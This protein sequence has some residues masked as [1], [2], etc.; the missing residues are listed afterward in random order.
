VFN[1]EFGTAGSRLDTCGLCHGNFNNDSDGRNAYGAAFGRISTH[2]SNPVAALLALQDQDPDQDGAPSAEEIA[3]LFM[4]GWSCADAGEASNAPEDLDSYVDPSNPGCQQQPELDC[5]DGADDDGDGAV[6]CADPDCEGLAAGG[7]LTGQPGICS[8]GMLLCQAGAEQCVADLGPGPEGPTG[9]ATCTDSVDN[10]CDGLADA[11]DP[12]CQ[13]AREADCSNGLDDDGDGPADCADPD[14]AGALL[15]SCDTQ[16]PGLCAA[17]SLTCSGGE[18]L[19]LADSPAEIEAPDGE[20]CT[21]SIDNDCDGLTDVDDP[22]C[23]I[24]QQEADVYAVELRA[25][26]HVRLAVGRATSR[27]IV[28]K[29]DGDLRSQLA[30]VEL[31][32][33]PIE[34]VSVGLDPGSMARRVDPGGGDSL[35]RFQAEL[36]CQ[37]SGTWM[38]E[39]TAVIQAS[40]NREGSD[41]RL[42]ASTRVICR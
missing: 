8:A 17:G 30:T 24:S 10:D 32:V 28:V 16:E 38:L 5:F 18:A 23:Q 27:W 11:L 12:G 6:D 41:D 31:G 22:D 42:S 33:E 29:A 4:P 35:F 15:A 2:E 36:L 20:S 7:C 14:C 26:D 34:A 40:D 9:E 25:P 37:S 1:D 3:A 21:D 13:E 39:W 19:C